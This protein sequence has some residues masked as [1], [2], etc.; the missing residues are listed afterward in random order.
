M[1]LGSCRRPLTPGL[2]PARTDAGTAMR[3]THQDVMVTSF[4]GRSSGTAA[5]PPVMSET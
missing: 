2:E 5:R 4:S 1:E 3:T